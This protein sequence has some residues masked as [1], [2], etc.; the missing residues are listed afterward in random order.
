MTLLL[1]FFISQLYALTPDEILQKVDDNMVFTSAKYNGKM[2]IHIGTEIRTK[3]YKTWAKGKDKAFIIFTNNEDKGVRYL[4]REGSL[5]IYFPEAEE[6]MKISGHM[7][8]ESMMGSDLSYEDALEN[9]KLKER[10]SI[11]QEDDDDINGKNCYV[12]DLKAKTSDLTYYR[13]KIWIDKSRFVALREERYSRSGKLL[14]IMTIDEIK[15]I[16]KRNYPVR[17][18]V[19]NVL[20]KN[21]YTEF[22][23][24]QY[25]FDIPIDESVFSRQSLKP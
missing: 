20:R 2:I 3:T 10:Y 6:I 17:M 22:S 14:R 1:V 4:K 5:W 18:T 24:Y 15:T 23:L 11:T 8:R 25:E 12:L 9:Q 7:L 19:Q 13:R 21:T 16:G